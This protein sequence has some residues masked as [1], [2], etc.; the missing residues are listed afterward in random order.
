MSHYE[1]GTNE[2][3]KISYDDWKKE[4]NELYG[5][6]IDKL[7]KHCNNKKSML[8]SIDFYVPDNNKDYSYSLYLEG[9]F[10][11]VALFDKTERELLMKCYEGTLISPIKASN[12]QL[13][14]WKSEQQKYM[15]I[16][17]Q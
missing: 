8:E 17:K 5:H 1:F 15:K 7:I 3:N 6:N 10:M 14:F 9:I 16:V 13:A 12:T 11:Q 2:K 4:Y